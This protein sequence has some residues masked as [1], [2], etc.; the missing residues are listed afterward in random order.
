MTKKVGDTVTKGEQ[1]CESGDV[2][3]CPEPHLHLQMHTSQDK[4]ADTVRFAFVD[5]KGEKYF[6]QCGKLYN[7]FGI[8]QSVPP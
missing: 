2:G 7:S 8:Q 3:F 1:I 4:K 5:E 6:A